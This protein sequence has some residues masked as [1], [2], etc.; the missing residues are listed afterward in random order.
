[1]KL[2]IIKLWTFLFF[3]KTVLDT[4]GLNRKIELCKEMLEV[5]DVLSPGLGALRSSILNDLY[6]CLTVLFKES[7][8]MVS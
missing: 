1:M 7:P 4:N 2:I 8:E 6:E 3:V 5:A